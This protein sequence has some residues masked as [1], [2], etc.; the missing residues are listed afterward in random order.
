MLASAS[1]LL[2]GQ[3]LAVSPAMATMSSGDCSPS[4]E[5]PDWMGIDSA[6]N[7][8]FLDGN[9]A[10]SSGPGYTAPGE[11]IVVRGDRPV[12]CP[13]PD[14]CLPSP[15]EENSGRNFTGTKGL[16]PY[17]WPEGAEKWGTS[18]EASSRR[19]Q[20]H[21]RKCRKFLAKLAELP[22]QAKNLDIDQ[23]IYRWMRTPGFQDERRFLHARAGWINNECT[24]RTFLA[25]PPPVH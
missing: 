6:G 13:D 11:T 3:V 17:V 4:E 9:G 23:R 22:L 5:G 24:E 15:A 12:P 18:E 19:D 21:L 20:R 7:F 14:V 25:E 2:G 10:G 16:R 8:C 1:A